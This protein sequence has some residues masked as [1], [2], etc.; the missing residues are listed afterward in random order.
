MEIILQENSLTLVVRTHFW[1]GNLQS[2][3][4]Y[5]YAT[6]VEFAKLYP[7]K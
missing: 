4:T 2:K 5:L 6:G 1:K 3:F 7:V